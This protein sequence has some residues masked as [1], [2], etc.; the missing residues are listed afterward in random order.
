[1]DVIIR[2]AALSAAALIAACAPHPTKQATA[3]PPAPPKG[4][5]VVP[6]SP[7]KTRAPA[8][9]YTLDHNHS[10]LVFRVSHMGFSRYVGQFAKLDGR[11]AFDPAHPERMVVKASVDA[12]SLVTPEPPPGF[13]ETIL[14]KDWLNA[15]SFPEITFRSTK[16]AVVP[17]NHAQVTGDLTL[18][19][20]T[21]PVTLWATFNGGYPANV[22]DGARI[23]FSAEGAFR[24]SDFGIATG[25]PPP[26]TNLGV[27]DLVA[28]TLETEWNSGGPLPQQA[29]ATSA[30][31]AS[32]PS[33]APR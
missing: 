12:R 8:G 21:R 4:E 9:A 3:P 16:V 24:R 27:G 33:T 31:G 25:L 2:T 20:V 6:E 30:P 26:G 29:A 19:G 23:G 15:G 13:R 7:G 32:A 10:T 22:M 1:M 14:G 11:L 5:P 28:V 18:H 17:P